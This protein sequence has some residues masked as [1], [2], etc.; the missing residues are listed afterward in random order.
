[1]AIFVVQDLFSQLDL[2]LKNALKVATELLVL[3]LHDQL[4][5]TMLKL[6]QLHQAIAFP[7]SMDTIAPTQSQQK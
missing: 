1:M 4:E 2:I 6:E 5:L 3:K 7:A